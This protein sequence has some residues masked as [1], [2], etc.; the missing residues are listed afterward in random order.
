[1]NKALAYILNVLTVLENLISTVFSK[2]FRI[3][4]SK[5]H[6]LDGNFGKIKNILQAKDKMLSIS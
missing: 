3:K 4:S 2:I 1:M 6:I 5:I